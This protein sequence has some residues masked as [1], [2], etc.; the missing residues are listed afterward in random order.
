MLAFLAATVQARTPQPRLFAIDGIWT[1]GELEND[2]VSEI[3]RHCRKGVRAKDRRTRRTMAK[4]LPAIFFGH[5]NPMNAVTSNGYTE[6]WRRMGQGMPRPK[7]ILSISAHWFVPQT[8]VTVSTAP[9]TNMLF[10]FIGVALMGCHLQTRSSLWYRRAGGRQLGL[11]A[12]PQPEAYIGGADKL[13]DAWQAG[14]RRDTQISAGLHQAFGS[15]IA[16]N[17][18]S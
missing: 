2:Q 17:G 14:Q 10:P 9:R 3:G 7:A 6:A 15:W 8:G 1:A 13:F 16:A 18:K 4:M 12:M 5:C 11:P